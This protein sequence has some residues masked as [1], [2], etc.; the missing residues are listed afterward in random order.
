MA[1][2]ER[3]IE[4]IIS[5]EW[6]MFQGVNN[7]GGKASCQE[8]PKTFQVMRRSQAL[9]RSAEMLASYHKDLEEARTAGIN[10]MTEKYA[11]MMKYTSP[12]EFEE[13]RSI[14]P[15]LSDEKRRWIRRIMATERNFQSEF[16]ARYPCLAAMGRPS[17]R[18]EERP[19]VTS[20]ETYMESELATYSQNTLEIY[21]NDIET[22]RNL[23]INRAELEV[24]EM[25]KGYGFSDLQQAEDYCIQRKKEGRP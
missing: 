24:Y 11:W 15:E 4:E 23:G 25:M 1:T 8:D 22:M 12:G 19:G 20:I 14:L 2:K 7:Q 21:C 5:M 17:T 6:D 10:L 13:I 16:A 18:E 3:L 9:T